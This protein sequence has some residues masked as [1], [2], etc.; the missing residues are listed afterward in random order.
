M[1]RLAFRNEEKLGFSYA[2]SLQSLD[3][4]PAQ[5]HPGQHVETLGLHRVSAAANRWKL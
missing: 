5:V 4:P 2:Y 1:K 3:T